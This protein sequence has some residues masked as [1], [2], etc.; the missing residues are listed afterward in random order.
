METSK[1]QKTVT[2][3]SFIDVID[4]LGPKDKY[5]DII[6][7]DTSVKVTVQDKSVYLFGETEEVQRLLEVFDKILEVLGQGEKITQEDVGL[8]L[9]QSE[10][11]ES[12]QSLDDDIVVKVGRTTVRAKTKHQKEYVDA[13]R[14]STITFAVGVAGSA[15]T[16]LA[17]ASAVAA[18]K[19]KEVDSIVITRSPVALDNLSI[20]FIPGSADEKMMPYVSPMIDVLLK[21]YTQEKLSAMMES[22][23][24]R[25][26]PLAFIRGYSF[27]NT[28]IILDEAQN[29]QISAYKS[30]LT[31]LGVG[32]KIVICGDSAQSDIGNSSGLN[33][34]IGIMEHCPGVSVIRMTEKDIVRSGIVAEVIKRFAAA[35]Y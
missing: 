17:V 7:Q 1:V 5:L 32:S 29:I 30:M 18:L 16:F 27:E 3:P 11:G 2:I 28:F 15:K 22:G 24:I 4:V 33:K 34:A 19:N 25:I 21:F 6:K 26:V 13:I 10:A 31:R 23:K 12:L 8:F 14:E 20:G 35:G 9:R